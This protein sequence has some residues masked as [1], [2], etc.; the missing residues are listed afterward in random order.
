MSKYNLNINTK[1]NTHVLAIQPIKENIS[2]T[3]KFHYVVR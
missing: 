3:V 1:M 2:S